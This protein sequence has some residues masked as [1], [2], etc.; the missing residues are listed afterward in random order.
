MQNRARDISWILLAWPAIGVV[1]L[2]LNEAA[3]G[4]ATVATRSWSMLTW[5]E[6]TLLGIPILH[7][8][9]RFPLFGPGWKRS[10]PVHFVAAMIVFPLFHLG[11]YLLVR[12]LMP[13]GDDSAF[14]VALVRLPRHITFG[15][16]IYWTIAFAGS[17]L[18][19]WRRFRDRDLEASRLEQEI[20]GLELE[21]SIS[22]LR[23][24][25]L[26]RALD[27]M[28]SLIQSDATRA[29]ALVFRLSDFLRA[30]LARSGG[31]V[32]RELDLVRARLEV[33]RVLSPSHFE[34]AI[35]AQAA[36]LD[37]SI[38][39][40]SLMR[41]AEEALALPGP[42]PS[43]IT[44]RVGSDGEIEIERV[45]AVA[46]FD[47]TGNAVEHHDSSIWR[48][49]IGGGHDFGKASIARKTDAA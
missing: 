34:I 47:G 23:P 13:H 14:E 7:L 26:F 28:E 36:A 35:E 12:P 29:E 22:R 19:A 21:A 32:R 18:D 20:S 33:E 15:F 27:A 25:F 10:L 38:P 45:P 11:I 42:P 6:W 17:A 8:T 3:G 48:L 44:L 1:L 41:L 43:S 39:D 2:L 24:V 40:G 4:S 31:S 46:G 37:L 30:T 16:L 5:I 49:A 9:R